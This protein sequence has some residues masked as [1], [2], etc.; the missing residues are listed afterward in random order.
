MASKYTLGEYARRLKKLAQQAPLLGDTILRDVART[1]LWTLVNVTPVRTGRAMVNW[2]VGVDDIVRL[3]KYP[4]PLKPV[5]PDAGFQEALNEGYGVIASYDGRGIIYI[6][7]NAPYVRYL[8]TTHPSPQAPPGF[9]EYAYWN[10][11]DALRSHKKDL[12]QLYNGVPIQRLGEGRVIETI[13]RPRNIGI[14]PIAISPKSSTAGLAR[15]LQGRSNSRAGQ[16][17]RRR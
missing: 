10:A 12:S 9:I 14:T 11:R 13:V 7:N 16:S 17:R 4:Q 2:Q 1:V 15:R 5:T 3:Y 8:N 6:T